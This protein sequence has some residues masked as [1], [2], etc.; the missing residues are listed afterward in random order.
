M[1]QQQLAMVHMLQADKR[2]N[3]VNNNM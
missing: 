2:C 3:C 1:V